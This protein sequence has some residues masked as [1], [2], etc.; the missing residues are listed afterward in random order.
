M[1]EIGGKEGENGREK[2]PQE[3]FMKS[4]GCWRW[5]LNLGVTAVLTT[6][7][8]QRM[9]YWTFPNHVPAVKKVEIFH[10]ELQRTKSYTAR[11]RT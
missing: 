5:K 7:P 1:G 3:K 2:G 9:Q 6:V 8:V 4:S 10:R 11:H